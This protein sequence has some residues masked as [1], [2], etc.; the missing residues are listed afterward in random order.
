MVDMDKQINFAKMGKWAGWTVA[1]IMAFSFLMS[2]FQTVELGYTKVY[3]NTFTGTKAVFHGPDWFISPPIIG[4]EREYKDDTTVAFSADPADQAKFTSVSG[5]IDIR[6]AD[7]YEAKLPLTARFVLPTDDEHMFA[8]DKS[9][10]SYENLVNSLY[11]KTMI[12]VTTNTAQQFTAEETTQ[13]GLNALKSAISDQVNKGVYVTERKR[14]VVEQDVKSKVDMGDDKTSGSTVEQQITVWKAVPKVDKDGHKLRNENPVEKYGIE[15]SQV[16][17]ADP[18]PETLLEK[19]LIA[20]KTSVAKKILSVQ[21]QDN[22][23]ED[24]KTAKLQGQAK[25]EKAEQIKLIQADAQIIENEKNVK[26]AKLQAKREIVEREKL[27]SLAIIDK[28]KQLQMSKANEG[29]QKANYNAA[30]YEGKSIKEV[31][32]AK[33]A[34]KKA[35]YAAIDKGVLTLE[36]SRVT[37]LAKYEALKNGKGL[38]NMPDKVIINNGVGTKTNTTLQDL[39][40]VKLMEGL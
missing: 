29:I 28:N 12:D 23:K 26:L 13:G 18:V 38:V 16:N 15:V 32:F 10:R 40:N 21:E 19:L 6:F 4:K 5:P 35:D 14:V 37:Q 33:A 9:F 30:K 7:T 31:G 11:E 39:A 8:V 34:V 2:I 24:I 20:K 22:A 3:Q 36:V 1:G 25:R 27:A 17:L